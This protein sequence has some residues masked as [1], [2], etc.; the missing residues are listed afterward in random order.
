MAND[1]PRHK[2]A[3]V[4]MHRD[5][6]E[7]SYGP[8]TPKIVVCLKNWTPKFGLFFL[9]FCEYARCSGKSPIIWP[10]SKC[11]W[12]KHTGNHVFLCISTL[13][14]CKRPATVCHEKSSTNLSLTPHSW[15]SC[16]VLYCTVLY[17]NV[18]YSTKSFLFCTV[19]YSHSLSP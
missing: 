7:H 4:G 11:S 5:I 6:F 1:I 12:W 18:L 9:F 14:P 2:F 19:Q 10:I 8:K 16:T 13:H 3:Y 17:C 15:S